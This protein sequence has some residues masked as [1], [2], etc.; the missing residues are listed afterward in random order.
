MAELHPSYRTACD[1]RAERVLV[2]D[3]SFAALA[4]LADERPRI[5]MPPRLPSAERDLA[6]VVR[7]GIGAGA[8]EAVIRRAGGTHLREVRCFDRYTGAPLAEGE[9]SLAFRLRFDPADQVLDD[10]AMEPVISAVVRSLGE[11]LGARLRA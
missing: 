7:D 5:G 11:E 2:A 4:R 3:L 1:V 8:V 9:V 10:S 6:V